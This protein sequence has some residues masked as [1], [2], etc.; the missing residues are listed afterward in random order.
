MIFRSTLLAMMILGAATAA[1][2]QAGDS[3][4]GTPEQ[5]EACAPDVRKFCHNVKESG[6]ADPYLKCLELN[7]SKL[8]PRCAG[9][10]HNYGK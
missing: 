4:M 9:M 6:G 3:P 7:R 2:A 10:L 1:H 5:R 8:S